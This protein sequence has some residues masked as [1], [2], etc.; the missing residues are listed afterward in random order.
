MFDVVTIGAATRDIFVRSK[1][2]QNVPSDSA[3]DGWNA[4][5]PL[6]A[7][8]PIDELVFETGGGATN[9]AVT[10]RRFGLKTA[11]VSC[12]GDDTGGREI[13]T[14]LKAEKIDTRG[15]QRT[16]AHRTAYSI[17][18]VAG[19]GNRAILVARGA[20][21]HLDRRTI[22]WQ[23]LRSRWIYFT[24]VAG[25]LALIQ[26]VFAH[27]RTSLARVAWNPG[28]LEIAFGRK[29]L[30]PLLLQT[31]V[32]ILNREE[33]AELSDC[34]PRD[35]SCMCKTLGSLPRR[36]LVITDGSRGASAT[37][38][39]VT[40]HVAAMKGKV[41]N[42]TGAGDAFGSGCVASLMT[43]GDIST[44]LRVGTLN[45]FS[46]VRHMGAQTGIVQAYPSARGL[47]RVHITST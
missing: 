32:L 39:G 2:F 10:F 7:K 42:T 44:A 19:T 45:A 15:V 16:M 3:P 5:L 34:S 12:V 9:A 8:I 36:V 26:D 18:L 24:S 23:A 35:L 33:A 38:R 31:D 43:D 40:W 29:K 30:L 4:C 13:L 46:V 41:V 21:A 14:Q 1:R 22:D 20:S 28:N 11:C 27:A 25:K 6:G 17:I 47:A 37:A